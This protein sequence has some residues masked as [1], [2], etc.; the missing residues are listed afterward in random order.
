MFRTTLAADSAHVSL[1]VTPGKGIAMQYRA[2]AGAASAQVAQVAGA[3]AVILKLTRS[4]NTFTGEW[5]AD[6]TTWHTVGS[7]T[8]D[9]GAEPLA[10][11]PF[12]SHN[13]SA[14]ATAEGGGVNLVHR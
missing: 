12:T 7:I 13:L 3:A 11:I 9:L 8:V 4:G 10:G 6:V 14:T 5:S 1:F 2:S